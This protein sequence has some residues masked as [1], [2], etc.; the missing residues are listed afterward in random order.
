MSNL[1]NDI[2]KALTPN[3]I[4]N[5][6]LLA[7]D[8]QGYE[9]VGYYD[10]DIEELSFEFIT[11]DEDIDVFI[12]KEDITKFYK[13]LMTKKWPDEIKLGD[14]HISFSNT[15][16]LEFGYC[17]IYIRAQYDVLCSY[18][19][20]IVEHCKFELYDHNEGEM[21]LKQHIDQ[22]NN[23]IYKATTQY[24]DSRATTSN[25][26]LA[27]LHALKKQYEDILVTRQTINFPQLM[28]KPQDFKTS[29]NSR[30]K[31]R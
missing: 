28:I 10:S 23:E 15:E 5:D 21:Y 13:F 19:G 9:I 3:Y 8:T 29:H 31:I 7:R 2:R 30:F 11:E 4:D 1:A 17:Q 20:D 18:I 24:I 12:S 22:I 14:L 25:M 16:Y 27:Q 6:I 26:D